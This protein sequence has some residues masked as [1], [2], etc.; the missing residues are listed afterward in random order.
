M[1]I[2]DKQSEFF[3]YPQGAIRENSKITLNI[4]VKRDFVCTPKVIIEKRHDYNK[5]FYKSFLF[6]WTGTEKNYDLYRCEF[7]IKEYG[8]YYY[9]FEFGNKQNPYPATHELLIYKNDYNTPLWIKGGIIYHI[10]VDR[11]YKIKTNSKK[12]NINVRNDW[13][14]VPNYLPDEN[15]KILNNDFFGGNIDG[16]ISK[17]PYL[18]S[19][20]VTAIYLSPIFE[21]HSN[22]KY[23]VGDYFNID[24]MFGDENSLKSLCTESEKYGMAI[25]LDAVLNHSGDDSVYFNKYNNY[26]SIGAYQSKESPY[27]NW[28]TFNNWND[29]YD[30]WWN[31]KILPTLNKENKSYKNFILGSSG[32]LKYWLKA[33]IKGYRLDVADE[34]PNEFLD[35]L[36]NSVKTSDSNAL[37]IGEVWEDAANKYSYDKLKEYF[38]GNQLDSVTN[39][40]LRT[41]IIEYIKNK[42]CNSLYETMNAITEK[43]PPQ[44]INCL[45]NILST[46][47]TVRIITELGS[48]H[49][50]ENKNKMAQSKLSNDEFIKAIKLLKI[51]SL[52]QMTMP[53]VP[54]IYYGDEAGMEGWKD[55][56]N[57]GCFPWE[58]ENQEI[59]NHYKFLSKLRKSSNLF[60]NGKYKC[61]VHDMGV[62]VFERYNENQKIVIGI[63]LSHNPITLNFHENMSE[64][65]STTVGNKFKIWP[66]KYLILCTNLI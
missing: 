2:F 46:H 3:R 44:A 27:L 40:P 43:Y 47:D 65:D 32:V 52:L 21:A 1:I 61:L 48:S 16:I 60:V 42:D 37:I 19:L 29:D 57:R 55:P 38:C 50:P 59:L 49:V 28:Y 26:K 64:F 31:I 18:Q 30:C 66:E 15:G 41:A 5:Q 34:L 7:T 6:E 45:M 63:N 8:N 4:Y 13:G 20:G 35:E 58:N 53:G 11:F 22:H 12:D 24:P 39:Y 10:F 33:G 14:N 23:D 51:A 17:L 54:C 62:F 56:F 36:R 25:I 9:S